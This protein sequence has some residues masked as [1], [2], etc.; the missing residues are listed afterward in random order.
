MEKNGAGGGLGPDDSKQ[1]VA[2][3]GGMEVHGAGEGV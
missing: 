1:R 3:S 2:K